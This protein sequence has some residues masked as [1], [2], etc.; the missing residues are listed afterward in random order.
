VRYCITIS[1]AGPAA[2]DAINFTD[3]IPTNTSY[4]PA[5]I[6][7]GTSCGAATTAEDDDAIDGSESDTIGASISGSVISITNSALAPG[8]SM[9]ITFMV[10]ID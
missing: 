7:S 5:S 3:A 9:A 1:N 4:D 2:A 8:T 10:T 6:M